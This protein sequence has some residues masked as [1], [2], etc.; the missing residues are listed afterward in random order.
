MR[1]MS[2]LTVGMSVL[3]GATALAA[4]PA[5]SPPEAVT[6]Q[7]TALDQTLTSPAAKDLR[8]YMGKVT[9]EA[10]TSSHPITRLV[11]LLDKADRQ[12]IE[13]TV[14]KE[15]VVLDKTLA[16]FRQAWKE[17]YNEDFDLSR[18]MMDVAFADARFLQGDI[19][20]QAILASQRL[21]PGSSQDMWKTE[22]EVGKAMG[23]ADE[24]VKDK[25]GQTERDKK[26]ATVLVAGSREERLLPITLRFTDEGA[27]ISD[28]R[29]DCPDTLTARKLH[30]NL[31]ARIAAITAG[32]A[33]WPPEP[34]DAY[35][36]VSHQVLASLADQ[37]YQPMSDKLDARQGSLDVED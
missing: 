37:P 4:E 11:D 5:A 10:I 22:G 16:D 21:G 34:R 9:N 18:S 6:G 23:K 30:D 12:R 15:Y 19:S 24:A 26:L 14:Q 3:L 31:N 35:R 7:T 20:D 13:P 32:K 25:A 28:W 2:R 1:P 8:F 29:L 33:N 27:L 36:I 17:K